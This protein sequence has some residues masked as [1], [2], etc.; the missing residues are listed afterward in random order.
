MNTNGQTVPSIGPPPWTKGVV[1]GIFSVGWATRIP[2]PSNR[3]TLTFI[4]E[5]R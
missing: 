3:M 2:M 1:A 5:L 4:Y